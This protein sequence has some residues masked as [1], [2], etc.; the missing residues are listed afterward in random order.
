MAANILNLG[1]S[2]LSAAQLGIAT[3]GQNIANASTPGYSREVLIQS[4]APSQL[5]GGVYLGL[6]VNAN[7]VQRQYDQYIAQQVNSAT[8]SKAQADS[9]L[10]QISGLNNIVADPTAGFTPTLQKFFTSIQNL[11]ASPNGTAGAAARQAALSSAQS[12]VGTINGLQN[13]VSQISTDV[14]GQIAST[15]TTINAYATQ[16]AQLND[17]IGKAQSTSNSSLPNDLLDQRDYL[18]TQLSKLTSVS[19]VGEGSQ[20][21]VFIGNGQPLVLGNQTNALQVVQSPT[22]PTRN[23]VAYQV[24]GKVIQIAENGLPGGTL[25]GLMDFRA[26]MLTATQNSIGRVAVSIASAINQQQALGQDLNGAT[27]TNLFSINSVV[28]TASGFNTGNAQINATITN[29]SALT[30]SDY[31]LQFSG[32]KYSV[33]R[34]SDGA[35]TTPVANLPINFDGVS[36]Q[37]SSTPV[38]AA[39]ASGD[40]FLIRPTAAAAA[41][42]SVAISDPNKLAVATPFSTSAP[43]TNTGNGAITAGVINSPVASGSTS[44]NGSIGPVTVDA[45]YNSSS[46]AGVVSLTFASPANTISG[47]PAGANVAVTVGG[48][49]TNYPSTAP[50]STTIPYTSGATISFNG[51]SFSIKDNG[52]AP[53]NGDTFKLGST[54]PVA[55]AKLTFNSATNTLSGF[56]TLP[57]PANVTV[58]NGATSTTY[59]GG[60]AVPYIA[61]AS[62][63]YN[64]VTFNLSGT[65]ANGD[66]FNVG[67]NTTGTGDNRNALLMQKIQTQNGLAGGTTT[68]QGAFAQ[69]VSLVGN[70]TN[71]VKATSASETSIL[72]SATDTQQSISGVNLDEEAS[73]LLKYQQSYQAA[74]KLMQIAGQLFA[75]LLAIGQ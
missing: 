73:N 23:E 51:M 38:G 6:G 21:N 44:I 47:F 24:K 5:I 71:E 41:S 8:T 28:S 10:S 59:P 42:I 16:L 45:S 49:T 17:S 19:V 4:S 40:Q 69:F 27:G 30:T 7:Q 11:A 52:T 34:L 62:Y 33:T 1:Q 39:P 22:D 61:G 35:T 14:N 74:G 60:T 54:I 36:F 70:K 75:T 20:Y 15:V 9:Y 31:S 37:L 68:I 72:K 26:N 18:V 13:Q 3:T 32:G 64:G 25:G 57:V 12:L 46:L 2:A 67:P 29:V 53:A 58:T 43:S 56:P 55:T 65:P 66:V 50:L 63:S 48:V